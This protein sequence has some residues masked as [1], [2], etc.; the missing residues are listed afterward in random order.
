VITTALRGL[1]TRKLRTIL[2]AVAIVLGVAM[3]TGTFVMTGTTRK[4][5]TGYYAQQNDGSTAV[6]G[7]HLVVKDGEQGTKTP[8]IPA[9][10]VERVRQVPGV[11]VAQGEIRDT[12]Q[13]IGPDGTVLGVEGPPKLAMSTPDPRVSGFS[14]T[15][16]RW[17]RAGEV[18]IDA[19]SAAQ[20]HV[21]V[22]DTIGVATSRPTATYR[23]S[24]LVHLGQIG[25]SGAT[26]TFFDPA[27]AAKVFGRSGTVDLI[28]VR[29]VPGVSPAEMVSRLEAAHLNAGVALDIETAAAHAKRVMKEEAGFVD[30][31]E[32]GLLGFGL[33]ALFVGAFIIFNTFSITVQ[34]RTR[35]LGLLRSLGATRAQVL[36]SVL[37]ESAVVAVAASAMGLGV[38]ILIAKGI[39]MLFD[40][41]G[42]SLPTVGLVVTPATLVP[43]FALGIGVTLIAATVPAFRATRVAPTA[44]MR[45]DGPSARP[46]RR[47][48]LVAG[49]L[50]F[51]TAV[52]AMAFGLLAHPG[53]A[54]DRLLLVLVGAVT[55]FLSVAILAPRLVIPLASLIGRPLRLAGMPGRI[56]TDNAR[57]NPG[58]TAVTA[59]AL[60]IG[61]ALVA[62]ISI[63][64]LALGNAQMNQLDK[65]VSADL[66]VS[67]AS[68]THTFDPAALQRIAS[69]PGVQEATPVLTQISLVGSSS[70]E[71]IGAD[72]AALARG[73]RFQWVD[74]SDAVARNLGP[75][76]AI[77]EASIARA[78]HIAVGQRFA[79]TTPTG[80]KSAFTLRGTYKD[81][82]VMTGY[83]IPTRDFTA[84]FGPTQPTNG[85][86]RLADGAD[87]ATTEAAIHKALAP[88]R[89]ITVQSHAEMRKQTNS[90]IQG[91]LTMVDAML[92]L[93]IL[94]S[95][96]GLVNTLVLSVMERVRELAVLRAIGASRRQ[97]R[98]IVRYESV[99]TSLIGAVLGL[100]VGSV[101]AFLC[102]RA[103]DGVAFT[104]PYGELAI[105]L[106]VSAVLGVAAAIF[107]AR[108]ASRMDP[109]AGLQYQ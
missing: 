37:L 61:V 55:F 84:L 64:I 58:R 108:R 78:S 81:D 75:G 105:V 4:A 104:L 41:V 100:G 24:G 83:I 109:L 28:R 10:L 60:M 8:P 52:A 94:I 53:S 39:F 68:D 86:V 91:L 18:A 63:F 16:G 44:A 30:Y 23:I 79:V 51:G 88:W 1:A 72:P 20:A 102:I 87:L 49:L 2:T 38:G 101:L 82:L 107:P 14:L 99:I 22:G 15:T 96:F 67:N 42:A 85:L 65:R 98:R 31:L 46:L 57:R 106:V 95:L 92:A 66:F 73:Y 71:A 11:A 48:S 74:G 13:L 25:T 21:G 93:S 54:S 56:A 50:L 33:I 40:A 29:A 76:G 9:S 36:R 27:T 6:I 5:F 103:V 17:P 89:G 7:G 19:T 47:R 32:Y 70:H 77:M 62:F 59:A 97:V 35:E 3:V 69:V 34:Q 43:G 26:F 90:D 80:K 45:E 12:A